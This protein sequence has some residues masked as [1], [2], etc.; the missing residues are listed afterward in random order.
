MLQAWGAANGQALTAGTLNLC[1]DRRPVVT[2]SF[3]TLRP[4]AHL[5][6]PA[7][8]A[9]KPGF[10]PRLYRVILNRQVQAW[11]YRWSAEADLRTFVGDTALCSAEC[12]CEIVAQSNLRA[13]LALKDGDVLD[14][15]IG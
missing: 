7:S 14:L 6:Q 10:D 4:Y 11:L 15:K 2:G 13:A 3:E 8:R 5:V 9:T 1:A 12:H